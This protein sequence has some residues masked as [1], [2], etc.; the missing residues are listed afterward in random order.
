MDGFKLNM[1]LVSEF[2]ETEIAFGIGPEITQLEQRIFNALVSELAGGKDLTL[3]NKLFKLIPN[4]F[5]TYE[6]H[7][8]GFREHKS[9]PEYFEKA[10]RLPEFI[11]KGSLFEESRKQTPEEVTDFQKECNAFFEQMNEKYKGQEISWLFI[12]AEREEHHDAK[13]PF[14]CK[15][16][17]TQ[18]KHV[19]SGPTHIALGTTIEDPEGVVGQIVNDPGYQINKALTKK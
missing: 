11:E 19:V 18:K 12:S 10:Y 17:V 13:N 5:Y 2:K 6:R 3:F 1:Q 4:R 15:F 9:L 16:A 7:L 14:N 8:E